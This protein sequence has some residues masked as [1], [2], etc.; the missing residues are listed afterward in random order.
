MFQIIS[1]AIAG[2]ALTVAYA[3][4]WRIYR[5]AWERKATPALVR[6]PATRAGALILLLRRRRLMKARH[7]GPRGRD[8]A[9]A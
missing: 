2:S 9:K 8:L 6:S 4:A 1:A 7:A 3:A 5:S